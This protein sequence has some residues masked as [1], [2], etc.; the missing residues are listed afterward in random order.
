MTVSGVPEE[1]IA[2]GISEMKQ[3]PG[4]LE[5]IDRGQPYLIVIDYA[6]TEDALRQLLSTVRPYTKNR[7]IVLFGCGGERDRG[8]RPLMGK[9]AGELADL[10]ILTSDNPRTEDPQTILNDVKIGVEKSG[11]RNLNCFLDRKDAIAE[12]I[13]IAEP[14]DT[15]VLAGKGHENYQI[16]QYVYAGLGL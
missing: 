1:P 8:K 10:V 9:A 16:D 3:V 5:R 15:L 7:L 2:A 14:G 12:A 6:H 11:N 4:R 13:R